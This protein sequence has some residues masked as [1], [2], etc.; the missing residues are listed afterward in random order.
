M[1]KKL[2]IIIPG[3]KTKLTPLPQPILNK[4]YSYLEVDTGN[5]DWPFKIKDAT[6]KHIDTVVFE[7]QGGISEIFSLIPASKKLAKFIKKCQNYDEIILFAKSLGG[8]IAEKAINQIKTKNISKLIYIATPHKSSN[9]KYPQNIKIINIYSNHDKYQK[10]ANKLLYL[11]FGKKNLETKNPSLENLPVFL[12]HHIDNHLAIVISTFALAK[13]GIRN[14]NKQELQEK[15]D[16]CVELV[17]SSFSIIDQEKSKILEKFCQ[18]AETIPNNPND[19][20]L[21]I[22]K[23]E[24]KQFKK[25]DSYLIN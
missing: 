22:L 18:I 21:K 17:R 25:I 4:L 11:G 6:D 10:L 9:K 1:T 16:H 3:S 15:A 5:N 23:D 7:W 2:L 20:Y 24:Y 19:E 14:Y 13:K 8:I 12:R